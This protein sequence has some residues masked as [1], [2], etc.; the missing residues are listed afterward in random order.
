MA[1]PLRTTDPPFVG[2]YRLLSRLG[3]G[4]M[5]S[6]FLAEAPGGR[7][8]AVKVIRAEYAHEEHF[9]ARF[10]SEV[11]RARQVPPFCTAEVLDADPDHATPYLV[12]EYV[13]GPTLSEVVA[14]NGPLT[15]GSLH[16]VA[17]GVATALAAIHGAGV[18]HRDLKPRNVLFA[19]G[20]PKVIDFGI[21][22]PLEPTSFHTRAEEVVGTLAYMAPERLDP[23]TD[24]QLTPA[25]D[26]FAWGAVVAYAGNGR[27]PFGGD[28]PAVTA[29]RILTQ[30]PRVENLPPYL[31]EMVDAA[32]DKQPGNRPTA[33]ELLDRLLVTGAPSGPPLPAPLQRSA[34]AAAQQSG[35][36]ATT[37][38]RRRRPRRSVLLAAAGATVLAALAGVGFRTLSPAAAPAPAPALSSAAPPVVPGP[39]IFDP[40][41][42]ESI[43]QKTG[44]CTYR[45]GLRVEAAKASMCAPYTDTVFPSSQSIAVKATLGNAQSCAAI[46]FRAEN[47]ENDE[48]ADGY[49]AAVC[50]GVV[51]LASVIDGLETVIATA[52]VATTTGTAH[53]LRL[54]ADDQQATLTVDGKQ[55]VRGPLT[56][57]SLTGG[58]VLLGAVSAGAGRAVVTFTDAQLRSGDATGVPAFMTGDAQLTAGM[59]MLYDRGRV[60]ILEPAEYV[61]GT[62]YCERFALPPTS[63]QCAKKLVPVNSGTRVS[64]P[65]AAEPRYLDYRHDPAQCLDP[66]THAGT[67]A[68]SFDTYVTVSSEISPRPSLVTIRNGQVATVARVDLE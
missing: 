55:A 12:V 43:F 49:R 42:K 66:K 26:V 45:N 36:F 68:V 39:S 47:K 6:V 52:R 33:A 25:V 62:E 2:P 9:R 38:S 17:V 46:S 54:V 44:S 10:R 51:R 1:D 13:D 19:L 22:R 7:L 28:T 11:S 57:S 65:I 40:L 5:G 67:C 41:R 58:R 31:A 60:A 34:E 30:P 37:S 3:E 32:L 14:E 56:E 4:G 61:T 48:D 59:H 21:A 15:G 63:P 64:L 24:W 50:P 23:D 20:Q 29:A 53:D 35:R 27:T 16:G 18:I 8:V